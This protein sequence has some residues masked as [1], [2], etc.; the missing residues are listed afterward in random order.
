MG[1]GNPYGDEYNEEVLLRWTDEIVK[2][3]VTIISLA[4]TIGV[5]TPGQIRDAMSTLVPKYEDVIFGIHLHSTEQNW[6]E[7]LN[8]AYGAG[9]RR[10]DGTLKGIGG[11]PMANDDLVGNMNTEWLLDFMEEKSEQ[12]TIDKKALQ[13]SLQLAEEIFI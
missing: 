1:F 4:D 6:R 11:C 3:D 13:D 5:A 8:A 12:I 7:K 10:F 2:Y 9:C